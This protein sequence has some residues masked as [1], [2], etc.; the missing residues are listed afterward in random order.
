MLLAAV[1]AF[2][3]SCNQKEL[4]Y[5]HWD[6]AVTAQ[7]Q[8]N[9]DYQRDW[10]YQ[11]PGG[12]DWKSGW[13]PQYYGCS[14][15]DMRPG[16]PEGIR[17]IEYF[18]GVE[19]YHLHNINPVSET[20]RL[21]PGRA[22]LLFFNNDT[23]FIVF[24]NIDVSADATATTR[25]R[26]RASYYGNPM[27]QSLK[28]EYTVNPPDVLYGHYSPDFLT[29][30]LETPASHNIT[31]KPL[32]FTYLVRYYFDNGLEY[33]GLARGALA[34]M[35]DKV[36]LT[37]GHTG[38]GQATVLYDCE[39]YD[40]GIE[41]RVNTFGIP[42]YPNPSY[43]RSDVENIEGKYALNLEVRLYNGKIF[44]F[45]WDISKDV[46]KQPRGGVIEVHGANI[47]DEDGKEDSGAFDVNVNGWGEWIDVPI[48]F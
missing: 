23:E 48:E 5:D 15:D 37:D 7:V 30:R 34:G 36:Y 44:D 25:V 31:M 11:Y 10:E 39:I 32:V 22:N 45:N 6:H 46:A 14:Y 13:N 21:N 33:V 1:A 47:S 16:V 9:F 40:W 29:E 4:C 38:E 12:P 24:S 17:I 41:A 28:S 2:L 3:T 19:K 35:A 18:D 27:L 20:V 43:S 42:D 26:S 8:F